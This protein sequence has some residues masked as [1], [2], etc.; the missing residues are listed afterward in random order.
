V[1]GGRFGEWLC[2]SNHRRRTEVKVIRKRIA[3]A[4]VVLALG[5]LGGIAMSSNTAAQQH[6]ASGLAVASKGSP[7]SQPVSTGTSGAAATSAVTSQPASQ[8]LPGAGLAPRSKQD[9]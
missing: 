9:D 4:L 8:V 6:Q 2:S 7:S 1:L 3:A 5:G